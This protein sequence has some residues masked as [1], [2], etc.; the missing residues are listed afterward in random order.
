MVKGQQMTNKDVNDFIKDAYTVFKKYRDCRP[1]PR[2]LQPHAWDAFMGIIN[3][4]IR[5]QGDSTEPVNSWI[6]DM[7][8]GLYRELEASE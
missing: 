4:Y 1:L 5:Y 6:M 2:E 7:A 8:V 3:Q